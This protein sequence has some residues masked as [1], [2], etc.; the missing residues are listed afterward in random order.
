[1]KTPAG[2]SI[3]RLAFLALWIW[4]AVL[5]LLSVSF[6]FW[7]IGYIRPHAVWAVLSL[8][9]IAAPL[10]GLGATVSWR[11]AKGPHR[12]QAIGWLLIGLTPLVWLGSY[13]ADLS[14]R[15]ET[16]EAIAI[17]TPLRVVMTWVSS[18]MDVEARWRYSRWVRGR[19]VILLDR[20]ET[21]EAERL[22]AEMD[23]HIQSMAEQLGQPIPDCE[24]PWVKGP[25]LGQNGRAILSWA[26]C[27]Q[28]ESQS[29]LT[30]L[31]RHEIAHTFITAISGVHQYPPFVLI[32][33][34]AE[35]QSKDRETMIRVLHDR[36]QEGQSYSLQELVD[37]SWY[38]TGKGPVYWEGGPLVIYLMEHYGPEKFFE[39][40]SGVRRATFHVDCQ[41][42]LD[43]SWQTIESKFWPWLAA[44]AESR[45]RAK[46]EESLALGIITESKIH[47][48]DSVNS[49]DWQ[50][51]VEG[52]RSTRHG[53]A[54]TLPFNAAFA[55]SLMRTDS[56]EK[57]GI[58]DQ[59]SSFEFRAVFE[60]DNFWIVENFCRHTNQ[61]LKFTPEESAFLFGDD[62]S[63]LKG[64]VRGPESFGDP[65]SMA[66]NLM[67][68][69]SGMN[70]PGNLLPLTE[71]SDRQGIHTIT[72][73]TRPELDPEVDI[74]GL[75][76]L[77]CTSQ[78]EEG[79][80][81]FRYELELDPTLEWL[82]TRYRYAKSEDGPWNSVS[83]IHYQRLG[84]S[85][86]PMRV[87]TR[88]E[89][90]DRSYCLVEERW[91]PL[92][93]KGQKNLIQ[94]VEQAVRTGPRERRVPYLWLRRS[95]IAAVL[96][97]P[98][99]GILLAKTRPA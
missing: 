3:P 76:S 24:F 83:E 34:W 73:L 10:V 27:G 99:V 40:Y 75:W 88:S 28:D 97:C 25:L 33:G 69:Y 95:L 41:S 90:D 87:S 42:I 96:A 62:L 65:R 12:L 20:G 11:L 32:E 56:D 6:L 81:G 31:D 13:F 17:S 77:S 79:H 43:E 22:V 50:E 45:A 98:L 23:A 91:Q 57:Q 86:V 85:I 64:W 52:Y 82:V 18:V 8:V 89:I 21:Q 39:L 80:A 49:G 48:A 1:M 70:D 93:E 66:E 63:S 5:F 35:S 67:R 14:I 44:E 26:L 60:N 2:S 72:K 7:R 9:F 55:V 19:H 51:F 94:R 47:L 46:E 36:R 84:D 59:Q 29:E 38:S 53:D 15:A 54:K 4:L 78:L 74:N 30:Y 68:I 37:S 92:G 16:R 58:L 61:Y 71:D